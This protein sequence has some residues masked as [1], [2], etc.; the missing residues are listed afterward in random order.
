[1][2][3]FNF[4]SIKLTLCLIVGILTG[5]NFELGPQ[6]SFLVLLPLFPFLY[7]INKNIDR[8]SFPFFELA[9]AFGMMALGILIVGLSQKMPSN[10]SQFKQPKEQ[11]WHLKIKEVL[12][13]NPY[14]QNYFTQVIA[15]GNEKSSG[16]LMLKTNSDSTAKRFNID[17]EIIIYGKSQPIPLP[18][19]PH[20]FDYKEYLKKQGIHHQIKAD[21]EAVVVV[22]QSSRTILGLASQV[23]KKII[24][25]L[26]EQHFGKDELAV[27]QA[28]L[29]GQRDD[30]SENTYNNYK[31]AGAVHIL[32]VS[33][34]HVGILLLLLEF[35]LS[36]LKRFPNGR[37]LKLLLIVLLLWIYAFIA[38][39]SP[40]IIRAVTMFSFFAYALYLNR[41]TNSFNIIAL[42]MLFILLIKPLMLFQVG[43]Q[44]SYAAVISIVWIYPKLQKFWFPENWLV[45]K[46][47]QLLSVS[48]S[49]QL[50]VLPISLYYFHQFP[51]LF[52][53]SNLIIVPFLGLI[54][55]MGVLV[56]FLALVN[57]LPNFLVQV[58]N[59]LI[60]AMNSIIDSVAQQENFVIK[61]I[62][63]DGF[64]MLLGYLVIVSMVLF[65]SRPKWKIALVLAFGTIGLQV[66]AIWNQWELTNREKLLLVHKARNTVLL[67]QIGS[68]L[69]I[70]TK[71]TTRLNRIKTD[72]MVAERITSSSFVGLRNHYTIHG[73]SIY[74]MD[75]LGIYPNTTSL[76]FLLLT[77]SPKINLER[78]LDSINPKMVLAD[79]SNY[80]NYIMR[81]G[82]TCAEKEI[83][84]HNT[85]EKGY[86]TFNLKGD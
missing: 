63:F 20:Q 19:N 26:K 21:L 5:Y 75:S 29:L 49:A 73:K 15:V 57:H 31:N 36:P 52:F 68:G 54:L 34:L 8:E 62:P 61:E 13:P 79:G 1:M 71:D 65:L 38:G 39:L 14:S 30:I 3:N 69:H 81:W 23:R 24:S 64:Q 77:Q 58:Y 18:I 17:D 80:K 86:Y 41:P 43:F 7:W 83:P 22:G 78:L 16:K 6:L 76:D 11:Y 27:I 59:T 25:Q 48:V 35:L 50:G 72:Y 45:R 4:V 82:R 44:M 53:V 51:S 37:T 56:I 66:H 47:W 10:Y 42:S 32:A 85:G 60:S 2:R 67:H 74:I 70:Y 9:V 46:V 12:K 55:G 84:F 40:S 33:G 28:L